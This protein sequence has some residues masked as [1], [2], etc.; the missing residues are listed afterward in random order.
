[1]LDNVEIF[2]AFTANDRYPLAWLADDNLV[3]ATN[4]HII[5][6]CPVELIDNKAQLDI[7]VPNKDY[8]GVNHK[9][10]LTPTTDLVAFDIKVL[11][12]SL[13]SVIPKFTRC[14]FDEEPIYSLSEFE[15]ST[16]VEY[17]DQHYNWHYLRLLQEVM[18]SFGG[19]W[20]EAHGEAVKYSTKFYSLFL[21]NNKG[22]TLVCMP[23]NID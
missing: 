11:E 5:I 3:V 1:M 12:T 6:G 10:S 4:G 19:D 17:K 21:Q 9:K 8:K 18:E 7:I 14:F 13:K 20:K 16:P 15:I 2:G 23:M 22:V